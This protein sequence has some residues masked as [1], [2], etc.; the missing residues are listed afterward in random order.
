MKIILISLCFL[1]GVVE[2][3]VRGSA[4]PRAVASGESGSVVAGTPFVSSGVS[5]A[6]DRISA[7]PDLQDD[8]GLTLYKAGYSS[9]LA[10]QW[11][12]ARKKFEELVRKY[13]RS[14]YADAAEYWTAYALAQTDRKRGADAYR[15]FIR[16]YQD[17]SSEY[18][19]DAVADMQK[20]GFNPENAEASVGLPPAPPVAP[21]VETQPVIAE[22]E[23][24]RAEAAALAAEAHELAY[25]VPK[26]RAQK[27]LDPETRLKVE[28]I[29]ALGHDAKDR[30]AFEAVKDIALDRSQATE[31]RRAA[32]NTLIR[33]KEQDLTG[34][35]LSLADSG[36][37]ELRREAIYALGSLKKGGDERVGKALA[38][39]ATD[40]QQPREIR[41]ASLSTLA[42][43][44]ADGLF[45][46][47][48]RIAKADPDLQMRAEA[49][50]L[51]GRKAKESEPRVIAV[52]KSI[53]LDSSQPRRVRE[54]SVYSL[55]RMPGKEPL[56]LLET[57]ATTDSEKRM[58][59][60][61]LYA[62]GQRREESPA[63]TEKLFQGIAQNANEDVDV[64]IAAL[65]GLKKMDEQKA[66]ALC[67]SL[68]LKDNDEKM[69]QAAVH[70]LA[71][72]TKDKASLL[73]TLIEIF[74]Q[75]AETDTQIKETALYGIANVGNDEA[76]KF[77]S[78]IALTSKDYELRRRAIYYLGSIGGDQAKAALME[79][80]KKK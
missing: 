66:L 51:I 36:E 25:A 62:L 65:Y 54:A 17:G 34:V 58:R 11:D 78:N 40:P 10:K 38:T 75:A 72:T 2:A 8:P 55:S 18:L 13:P 49:I 19:D 20:F 3:Q 50:Y 43:L 52:L 29:Y 24:L 12:A 33:F 14:K 46:V 64:R 27:E 70:L 22:A 35:F 63:E 68:A 79:V 42:R 15:L 37:T 59:L 23:E 5:I 74:H 1:A 39:Y 28:A 26:P 60:N 77:L 53:A 67:K 9:I 4:T 16:K 56:A 7:V 41:E 21:M 47:L 31:L 71:E 44:D 80:L 45:D 6:Q 76:V 57:M 48:E 69:R 30:Q 61:A 73:K 32:F